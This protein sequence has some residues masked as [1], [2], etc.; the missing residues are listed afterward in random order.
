MQKH[1]PQRHLSVA[2]GLSTPLRPSNFINNI[3][4]CGGWCLLAF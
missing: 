2:A 3:Q 1:D 4:R